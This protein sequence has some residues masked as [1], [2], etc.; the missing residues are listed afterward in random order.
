MPPISRQSIIYLR[1]ILRKWRGGN[2]PT[3]L[4]D[5]L[6]SVADD[7]AVMVVAVVVVA[8]VVFPSGRER[9]PRLGPHDWFRSDRRWHLRRLRCRLSTPDCVV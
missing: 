6:L 9:L 2:A 8:V 3:F 5:R 4:P 7:A 1:V